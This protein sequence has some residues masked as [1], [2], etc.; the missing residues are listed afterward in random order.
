MSGHRKGKQQ[1]IR[2]Y[3]AHILTGTCLNH[4]SLYQVIVI[5]AMIVFWADIMQDSGQIR[6]DSLCVYINDAWFLNSAKV[7]Y[8]FQINETKFLKMFQ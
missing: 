8:V 7:D 6:R 3:C 5:D 4:N 2:D 1:E